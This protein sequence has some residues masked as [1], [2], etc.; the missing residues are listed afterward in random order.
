V[1]RRRIRYFHDSRGS[2]RVEEG[3]EVVRDEDLYEVVGEDGEVVLE[4]EEPIPEDEE[5][6]VAKPLPVGGEAA[7]EA[8]IWGIG[9]LPQPSTSSWLYAVQELKRLLAWKEGGARVERLDARLRRARRAV[10]ELCPERLSGNCPIYNLSV[11]SCAID[12]ERVCAPVARGRE[13]AERTRRERPRK[14][15]GWYREGEGGGR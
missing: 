3:E 14:W 8:Y 12:L 10:F 13:L 1:A 11:K 2:E 15:R 9:P 5:E 7:V 6:V 4:D